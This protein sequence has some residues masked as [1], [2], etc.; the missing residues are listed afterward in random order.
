MN[1]PEKALVVTSAKE[2]GKLYRMGGTQIEEIAYVEAHPPGYEDTPG[3]QVKVSASGNG[4]IA[5]GAA[6]EEDDEF[7]RSEYLKAICEAIDTHIREHD[8]KHVFMI[9]PEHFKGQVAEHLTHNN[10]LE[11]VTIKYGNHVLDA[12]EQIND[13]YTQYFA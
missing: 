12:P 1:I 13:I 2:H 5:Q 4:P 11:V 6:K 9:E 10:N 7:N 3:N 8:I